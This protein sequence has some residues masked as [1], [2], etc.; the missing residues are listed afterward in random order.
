MKCVRRP[1]RHREAVVTIGIVV[2]TETG[3]LRVWLQQ[4]NDAVPLRRGKEGRSVIGWGKRILGIG[5]CG[6]TANDQSVVVEHERRPCSTEASRH[7]HPDQRT[8]FLPA[9]WRSERHS[10]P[11][12][13]P[14]AFTTT[15]SPAPAQIP[16]PT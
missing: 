12:G 16:P 8:P 5:G 10:E 6:V 7:I 11:Q 3:E 1:V 15:R 2:A 4:C 14:Q 9:T 13:H